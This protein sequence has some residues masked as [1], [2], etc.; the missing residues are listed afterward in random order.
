MLKVLVIL[1]GTSPGLTRK[2]LDLG[3]CI[4][5]DVVKLDVNSIALTAIFLSGL[6]K[7]IKESWRD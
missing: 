1:G 4:F 5:S 7:T 2:E 6:I 3:K